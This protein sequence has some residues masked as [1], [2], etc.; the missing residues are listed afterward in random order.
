MKISWMFF[1]KGCPGKTGD[2]R[3]KNPRTEFFKS[4]K[5]SEIP[6]GKILQEPENQPKP[7]HSLQQS[8]GFCATVKIEFSVGRLALPSYPT[9]V[10]GGG[11]RGRWWPCNTSEGA[12][13]LC[14]TEMSIAVTGRGRLVVLVKNCFSGSGLSVAFDFRSV[15]EIF[16][17]SFFSWQRPWQVLPGMSFFSQSFKAISFCFAEK[18]ASV[19]IRTRGCR[20]TN[21]VSKKLR[22]N[23]AKSS[24]VWWKNQRTE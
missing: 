14:W 12:A 18:T 21:P 4:E 2:G 19:P 3:R 22:R 13:Q 8:F 15:S 7:L 20:R 11:V 9:R 23:F 6:K 5:P 1:L 24:N 17:N 16:F 10:S